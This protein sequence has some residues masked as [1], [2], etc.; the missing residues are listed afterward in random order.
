MQLFYS[1]FVNA[2][3]GFTYY[4]IYLYFLEDWILLLD[5]QM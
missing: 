4:L 1:M 2:H 3:F 5:A